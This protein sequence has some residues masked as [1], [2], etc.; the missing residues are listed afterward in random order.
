[1]AKKVYDEKI[2]KSTDWGGDESTSNLPVAGSRVQEF[3]KEQL[4]SKAGVFHYDTTNNRY[5]VFSDVENRD[6]YLADPSQTSLIIGTFDAPFNYSAEITLSSPVYVA[7]LA[8]TKNNYIDFTFDTKN[9]NGQSVGE[10]VIVTYTFIKGGI[11]KTVTEK[12]QYGASVHFK[13]DDYIS[14][15]SNTITVGIVGQNTLAA[16][17][18]GITY[19]VVDLQLSDTYDISQSY[20]LVSSPA[21]TAAIPYQISGYGTKIMEWYLDGTLLDYIKVEDEI[22]DVSTTRT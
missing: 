4:N 15:G 20:D 16:T 12:Y 14:T 13:I 10:A 17:T 6:A 7:I 18:I 19:L 22:V 1:M 9:K 11:K 2:S 21:A 8:E 3:I 5:I